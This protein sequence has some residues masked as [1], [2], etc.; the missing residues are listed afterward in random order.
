[1]HSHDWKWVWQHKIFGCA[2]CANGG[3]LLSKFLNPPLKTAPANTITNSNRLQEGGYGMGNT[4]A[5]GLLRVGW[6]DGLTAE[7]SMDYGLDNVQTG[8]ITSLRLIY[9][10]PTHTL[11]P[12]VATLG[13]QQW[14]QTCRPRPPHYTKELIAQRWSCPIKFRIGFIEMNVKSWCSVV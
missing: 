2:L 11:L 14:W 4:S 13:V 1:M 12:I 8:I 9:Y 6:W 3:T 10:N 5:V 7:C